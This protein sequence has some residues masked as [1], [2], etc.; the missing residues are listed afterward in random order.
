MMDKKQI[1]PSLSVSG[2]ITK[3]DI[4]HLKTEGFKTIINNRPDGEEDGQP[5]SEEIRT[6]AEEMGM[7]YVHLPITPGNISDND[8]GDFS[9]AMRSHEGPVLAYCRTGTRAINL[10]ALSL[11][12]NLSVDAIL[13]TASKAGYDL[14]S[15]RERL[16]SLKG[17][18]AGK[19]NTPVSHVF[20]VVI[21]GG[22]AGGQSAAASLLKRDGD[23]DIAII[24]P[25]EEHYYQPGWTLVGGGV[26]NRNQTKRSMQSVMPKKATWIKSAVASFDPA[27]NRVLTEGGD[28][29]VYKALV[30]APGLKLNW[31]A[32][33]GLEETLGQN[34]VTSNYRF[35]LS[36]Y[37]WELVQ[38]LKKGK[39]IFT[40]PPM[41]IKCAGAPQKAMYLS[42]D[43]WLR[44]GTLKD[45]DV[46]FHNA[47]GVLFGVSDYVPALEKYIKK[48]GINLHFNENLIA[49]DGEKKAAT[50]MITD[51]DGNTREEI[52]E[53]DMLHVCPP[54]CPMDFMKNSP[55]SNEAGW[56][57][58]NP[59]TL[60][61]VKYGNIFG[62]GDGMSAPNA[63]TAAAVRKQAP[64][65]AHNLLAYLKNDHSAA[66]YDGYG[67]C[68]LTVEKGKIVLA[69]FGYGGK[70]QPT[71]PPVILDGTKPSRLAWFMKEKLLPWMYFDLMM[72]GHEWLVKPEIL[73]HSPILH[74]AQDACNF[75]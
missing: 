9:S 45:I 5:S 51:A 67:S 56:V 27:N 55:I 10:W 54:Q 48:Y 69:E 70:L 4:S 12:G 34:G 14:S 17:D 50:F 66:I 41:P 72:K 29:V 75:D 13:A 74:D 28:A 3:T 22:G 59:E 23:L 35:D 6:L 33:K 15:L 11:A 49:V 21:V 39:A 18:T 53:F 42:C 58:V 57:E 63:K 2:Q 73:S 24:E 60:Q 7:A 71:F 37:T 1:S 64:V 44:K 16:E 19:N 30:V 31:S 43:A 61:H 26:F 20:D 47:G 8:I 65:V 40:Q 68:P 62:I 46:H 25:R 52:R 38:G 36:S 32:V